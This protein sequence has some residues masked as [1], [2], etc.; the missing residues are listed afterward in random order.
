MKG[1]QIVLSDNSGAIAADTCSLSTVSGVVS[2]NQERIARSEELIMSNAGSIALLQSDFERLY[3]N[4]GE[5][6]HQLG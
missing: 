4:L 6:A 3:L 5:L 1:A 2:A